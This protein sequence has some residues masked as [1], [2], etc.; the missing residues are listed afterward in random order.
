MRSSLC[1]VG[2]IIKALWFQLHAPGFHRVSRRAFV[3]EPE[4]QS[5]FLFVLF[6]EA[7]RIFCPYFHY[8]SAFLS[9]D[10]S[11]LKENNVGTVTYCISSHM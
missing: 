9:H 6:G 8:T 11:C 10:L 7:E 2:G 1:L 3:M 5:S 4:N